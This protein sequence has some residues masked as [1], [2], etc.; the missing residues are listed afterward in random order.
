MCLTRLP[1]DGNLKPNHPFV[2]IRSNHR[3]SGLDFSVPVGTE[4]KAISDGTVIRANE[5]TTIDGKPNNYGNV[6]V[7]DHGVI[8]GQHVYSLY[9][10]LSDFAADNMA[11]Q[12]VKAGDIIGL[13]GGAVGAQGS[14]RSSGPHLH[15]EVIKSPTAINWR[16]DGPMGVKGG[17][18]RVDPLSEILGAC[19]LPP[20][21]IPDQLNTSVNNTKKFVQRFGD[22][23]TLDLNGDGINTVPL[24]NPPILF[25]HTGSGIKTGTGWIAPDDGFLVLDR[26][27]NGT[28]DNGTE[29]FGD[30]TPVYDAAG[31]VI[32]KARDGFDALAQLDTN[33]DGIVDAQD[34]NFYDLQVW[35][36]L[37]QDGISQANELR[38]LAD[39]LNITSI[40]VAAT[41]HSQMLASGNQMADIGSFI[42]AN[43]S[44]GNTGSVSNMADIN[45]ALDTFHRTFVTPVPLTL[46]A[47]QLTDMQGSGIVRD[48]REAANDTAYGETKRRVA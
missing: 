4:I 31:N 28:I 25:D 33:H 11:G 23:L 38:Y 45:L 48:L 1:I 42:Y 6:V 15:F 5:N 29:L 43:G 35:Q 27:G 19:D 34:A 36:D 16:A 26:N 18:G 22:P 14:G 37:S 24:T 21:S 10:H 8:D 17:V 7:I 32:G 9:A 40:N 3:H 30:N 47:E 46:A 44:T 20:P 39:D 41:Q 2:E 12:H 13:S